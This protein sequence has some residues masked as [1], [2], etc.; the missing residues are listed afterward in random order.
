MNDPV[1]SVAAD[2]VRRV[3]EV[4]TFLCQLAYEPA[5]LQFRLNEIRRALEAALKQVNAQPWEAFLALTDHRT[6][7]LVRMAMLSQRYD[8]PDM[9][10]SA[11]R[12]WLAEE[13][14][15]P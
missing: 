8:L 10:V 14:E 6:Q 4:C 13:S 9:T 2:G 7:Y 11:V 3:T 5:E 12:Q 15:K 1:D